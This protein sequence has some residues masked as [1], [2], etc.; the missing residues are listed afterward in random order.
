M[1]QTG[2]YGNHSS[3]GAEFGSM[4][5][6]RR[7]WCFAAGKESE[8][9]QR[10]LCG[11]RNELYAAGDYDFSVLDNVYIDEESVAYMDPLEEYLTNFYVGVGK[12]NLYMLGSKD[13]VDIY[14]S[15]HGGLTDL[16]YKSLIQ[17]VN[18]LQPT[19][20]QEFVDSEDEKEAVLLWDGGTFDDVCHIPC[21]LQHH[22][23]VAVPVLRNLTAG[24][25]LHPDP[26][27]SVEKPKGSCDRE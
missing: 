5:C 1:E 26:G 17:A 7:R 27:I 9:G 12:V 8:F 13:S 20:Y 2:Y 4:W 15:E 23:H 21:N 16:T 25:D 3:H 14:M 19:G 18:T 10:T 24:A 11:N 6:E 22:R